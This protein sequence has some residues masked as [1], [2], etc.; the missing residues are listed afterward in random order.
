MNT[1]RWILGT[2]LLAFTSFF[3][4]Q[5]QE[6]RLDYPFNWDEVDYV[7]ATYKGVFENALEIGSIDLISYIKL[8]IAKKNKD[9]K[10]V[11][12]LAKTLP[13]EYEDPFLMRHLHPSLPIFY[14]SF[15]THD[16]IKKEI[17]NFRWSNT[18][19]GLISILFFVFSG[20]LVSKNKASV[21]LAI[22]LATALLMSSTVVTNA[23]SLLNQHT[24]HFTASILYSAFLI[25]FVQSPSNKRAYVF[26]ICLA[27]LF[28]TL[29]MAVVTLAGTVIALLVSGNA[30]L[31]INWKYIWR[32]L[33]S[34]FVTI[35]VFWAGA[36]RT[37][38]TIKSLLNYL[39]RIFAKQ[40]AEYKSVSLLERWLEFFK[41]QPFLT[42]FILLSF[43]LLY[44]G[45]IKKKLTN[46]YTIPFV[47]GLFYAL[48]MSPFMLHH[49]YALPAFGILT[50]GGIWVIADLK[51]PKYSL[52]IMAILVFLI[53][54]WQY[55]QFDYHEIQAGKKQEYNYY[56]TDFERV[57]EIIEDK[58]NIL[59]TG[60]HIFNY[61]A[62]TQKIQSLH[63]HLINN[64]AFYQRINY[65]YVN[66][67][68]EIKEGKYEV[69]IILKWMNYSN[70][71]LE[72]LEKL[73][74]KKETLNTIYLFHKE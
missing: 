35:L 7:N 30:R 45:L 3:F 53:Q 17:H 6:A 12:E 9:T 8:G 2:V 59:A 4:V 49:V 38:G 16:N 15:F 61:Y 44:Y 1:M 72:E 24:F 33:V 54:I 40:N 13:T 23:F 32:A 5:N 64:P 18:F 66:I 28:L 71:T 51:L 39:Y 29:E 20:L 65:D 43:V 58:N 27:G 10:T 68:P 55:S 21:Y 11:A 14:W 47:V 57:N 60:N 73:G 52:I 41:D 31:L 50:F 37:G 34:F 25:Y 74:F 42:A 48:I 70:S 62:S 69:I 56:I 19:L 22:A 36:F 63:R 67:L 26:G 46:I